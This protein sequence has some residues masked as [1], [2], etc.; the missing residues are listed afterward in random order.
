MSPVNEIAEAVRNDSKPN[1]DKRITHIK[2][3]SRNYPK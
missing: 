2:F 3:M 1:E